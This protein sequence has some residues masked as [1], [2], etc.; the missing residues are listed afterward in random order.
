MRNLYTPI[1]QPVMYFALAFAVIWLTV[2]LTKSHAAENYCPGSPWNCQVYSACGDIIW[3]VADPDICNP[4]QM[5]HWIYKKYF[6]IKKCTNLNEPGVTVYCSAC[7]DPQRTVYCCHAPT[8]QP[9]CPNVG[10]CP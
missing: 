2:L 3:C 5:W 8:S 1:R 7:G 4:N 10:A 6:I 9:T